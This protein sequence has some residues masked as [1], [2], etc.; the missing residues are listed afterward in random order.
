MAS[1]RDAKARP[2][3]DRRTVEPIE[4][5]GEVGETREVGPGG[6]GLQQP[7]RA[8]ATRTVRRDEPPCPRWSSGERAP[9]PW[10]PFA[11]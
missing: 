3:K 8:P 4:P 1:D 10:R 5:G 6:S 7:G 2:A 11:P 9:N